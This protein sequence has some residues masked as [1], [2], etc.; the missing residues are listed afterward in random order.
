MSGPLNARGYHS[1]GGDETAVGVDVG[2]TLTKLA[3]GRPGDPPRFRLLP[4]SDLDA[5]ADAV[6]ALG[7]ARIG[8]TGGGAGGLS[9][10]LPSEGSGVAEF[11][12]WGT[13]VTALL[14]AGGREVA[15]RYLVVA[16]GTGTSILL[17]EG[18]KVQRV[19]GTALGGGTVVG[20][21]AAILGE[22]SFD[23]LAALA[24][25]GTRRSVDLLIGD[26]YVAGESP[27]PREWTAASFGR[28]ARGAERP[29]RSD[30]ASAVMGLVGENVGMLA[31]SAALLTQV[32]R[33]VFVGSTLRRNPGLVDLLCLVLRGYGRQ[34]E[35]LPDGEFAAAYGA[36]LRVAAG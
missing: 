22:R 35:H 27:L 1:D 15:P 28:L 36:L 19:G 17:V 2:A 25:G 14:A 3:W 30:L 7:A 9:G 12:A 31:G 34:P 4:S 10:R 13:G 11:D 20:L 24:A 18:H 8:L 23:A 5:V 33:V 6:Q 32:I 29:P 16:I 26:V 21:G